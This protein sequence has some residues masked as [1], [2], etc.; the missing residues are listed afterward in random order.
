MLI[1]LKKKRKQKNHKIFIVI[2]INK[3]NI[4]YKKKDFKVKIAILKIKI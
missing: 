3:K 2:K 4:F 1:L